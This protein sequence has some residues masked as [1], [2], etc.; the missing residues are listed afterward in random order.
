MATPRRIT[1]R[2]V[3]LL[4]ALAAFGCAKQ[5]EI[6]QAK[7][8]TQVQVTALHVG[9]VSV[10]VPT[11]G[12]I[13]AVEH[14]RVASRG[15]GQV[16][17]FELRE[18][19]QV[20]KGQI[21]AQLRSETLAIQLEA[22]KALH[23]Q[24]EQDYTLLQAGFRPEEIAQAMARMKAAEA[25]AQ[26]SAADFARKRELHESRTI[27]DQELE[28]AQF[29]ATRAEQAQ[30]EAAA[31]YELKK[32][33]NRPEEIEAARAMAEAQHQVVLEL[34]EELRKR[35]IVAPFAGYLVEKLVDVGEWVPEGGAVATLV[36]L[37]EVEVRVNVD[38]RSIEQV[39]VDSKVPVLIEALGATP[40]EGRVRAVVP[41]AAWE[42]G[43]RSFPVIVRLTNELVEGQPRMKEGMIAR[44]EFKGPPRDALLA[45]KDA[46]V[47]SSGRPIVRVVVDGDEVR[48]VA[49]EEGLSAG[50]FIEIRGDVREGDLVV[51]E[52]AE[53]VRAFEKVVVQTAETDDAA[54]VAKEPPAKDEAAPVGGS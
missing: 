33:G 32:A 22:A 16:E 51:T 25:V 8:L 21:L 43:S 48:D 30:A 15:S 18:G 37:E 12:N 44:I 1:V 3:F 28:E 27:T 49:V 7:P 42:Q 10:Q 53:R 20:A 34:E 54:R 19:A 36:S 11:V 31:D 41:R 40:F 52:G 50:E 14:S 9:P 26:R 24:K 46:I 29:E 39:A 38:E 45:H 23:H 13:M 2:P 6:K 47:R 35:T 17:Q 4:L 5:G